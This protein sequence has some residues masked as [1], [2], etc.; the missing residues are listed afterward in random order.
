MVWKFCK[1][2]FPSFLSLLF[3]HDCDVHPSFPVFS[4]GV[5]LIGSLVYIHMLG[6]TVD[7]MADGAK[8]LMKY[9][10]FLCSQKFMV[11]NILYYISYPWCHISSFTFITNSVLIFFDFSIT[12]AVKQLL[13]F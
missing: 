5:G 11:F 8:G 12:L 3:L 1:N 4:F 2:L 10:F 9:I 6:S 13:S 7:S